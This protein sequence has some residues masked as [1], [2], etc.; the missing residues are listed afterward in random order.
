MARVRNTGSTQGTQ[1]NCGPNDTTAP[2][3][4]QIVSSQ[5]FVRGSDEA[6]VIR[7][8]PTVPRPTRG[9]DPAYI[10]LNN[11]EVGT[12]IQLINL[13]GKPDADWGNKD[14]IVELTLTGRDVNNRQASIYLNDKQMKKMG[15]QPGDMYQLRAV[16]D[17][18]NAS[19]PVTAEL[20]PD[21]W[22]NSRIRDR[23]ANDQFEITRGAQIN[24]LDGE[25]AREN[26]IIKAVNDERPPMAIE[27]NM[28]LVLDDRF[29]PEQAQAAQLLRGQWN[30]LVE[31]VQGPGQKHGPR[32]KCAQR[33]QTLFHPQ[34]LR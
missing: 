27:D 15:L 24:A 6:S 31:R 23:G 34:T 13:S 33:V 1:N 26:L 11:V 32:G 25:A 10:E 16:D 20:E 12:K 8:P 7:N 4:P 9:R 28:S 5:A 18:G 3:Q 30:N 19:Q 29:T 21:D 2:P 14:D 17:A 22:A